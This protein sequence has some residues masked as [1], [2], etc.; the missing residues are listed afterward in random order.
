MNSKL[1]LLFFASIQFGTFSLWAQVPS[2]PNIIIIYADDL[3]Y[4]E[5]EP[6]GQTVIKTPN[7]LQLAKEGMLFTNFYSSSALC[8]PARCQLLTGMHSGHAAVRAN[9]EMANG[10]ESFTDL[11]EMGQLPLPDNAHTL[12]EMLKPLGYSTACIGKWGLGM[13]DSVGN[14]NKQ[15]FDYF[16]GYLDQKQAH[17]YYPTHL[18]ENG[19]RVELSNKQ[20]TVHTKILP[21]QATEEMFNSFIGKEYSVDLM[22]ERA[23]KFIE[24]QQDPY[25]LY[26]PITLPHLALQ[27]PHQELEMYKDKF[28][29][30]PYLGEKGYSPSK[31][32]RATYAAMISY[33]DKKI[34]EIIKQ[35]ELKG[36][37][38]NT[39]ILFTSDNGPA[40]PTGGTD[41]EFFNSNGSLRD[42]KGALYEGGIRVPCIIS[43]PT[44]I[45]PATISNHISVQYDIKATLA[46]LLN[47]PLTDTDGISFLPVL[48]G[49]EQRQ[50]AYLYFELA[51]YTGQQAVRMGNWKAVKRNMNKNKNA[52]W[53]LYNLATDEGETQNVA[54]QYPKVIKR[55]EKIVARS[56]AH[57]PSVSQWNFME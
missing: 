21:D 9:F 24:E 43:W 30:K 44:H 47:Q 41:P 4:G 1:A 6:Y 20:L 46:D 5:I 15:G 52:P 12:A 23:R 38:E 28:E 55:I 51:E 42:Y 8:A 27:V 53:E 29:D 10:P 18:W 34:G 57:H 48:Y 17:N 40:F 26:Y 32:P 37:R 22:A 19:R 25:L 2:K 49:K 14:P 11:R 36:Q 35:V 45:K 3:G 13:A 56:H 7:L 50:H 54:D 16:F 33:L 31:Y 39:I